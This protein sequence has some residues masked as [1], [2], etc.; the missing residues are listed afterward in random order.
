MGNW[1]MISVAIW[2]RLVLLRDMNSLFYHKR[3]SKR[4]CNKTLNG[5]AQYVVSFKYKCIFLNTL[6]NIAQNILGRP[7]IVTRRA[8][9]LA[10]KPTHSISISCTW[11]KNSSRV[12]PNHSEDKCI[13]GASSEHVSTT[14]MQCTIL[15][16]LTLA[17]AILVMLGKCKCKEFVSKTKTKFQKLYIYISEV[18]HR[19]ATSL[20]TVRRMCEWKPK[21]VAINRK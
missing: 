4:A 2:Q 3:Y 16:E 1:V 11:K 7:Q 12:Y 17:A 14:C 18:Q 10:N 20:E 19:A 21:M 15:W 13:N 5:A 6:K 9:R 8:Q